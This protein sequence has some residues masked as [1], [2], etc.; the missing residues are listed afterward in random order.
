[1]GGD[2]VLGRLPQR[3]LDQRR[4]F[5]ADVEQ[6]G[7]QPADAAED[8][9]VVVGG[10]LQDFFHPGA[11]SLVAA[12]Q[13]FQHRGAFR[14]AGMALAHFGQFALLLG[15]LPP[16]LVELFLIGGEQF[17]LFFRP[18]GGLV[19]AAAADLPSVV[20][21]RRACDRVR[22]GARRSA[23]GRH[24]RRQPGFPAN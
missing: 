23:G 22:P 16:I 2:N 21:R 4:G 12:D 11:E 20:A 3:D 9:V 19:A 7:H 18:A 5:H 6:V 15:E 10:P 14:G 13:F 24:R 17:R 8:G 1:M